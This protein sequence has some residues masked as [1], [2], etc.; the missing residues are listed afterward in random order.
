M[1][2]KKRIENLENLYIEKEI[3]PKLDAELTDWFK[4]NPNYSPC[5][6]PE[7]NSISMPEHL[8]IAFQ[9]RIKGVFIQKKCVP[10]FFNLQKF[11][12]IIYP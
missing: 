5:P 11:W 12:E 1:E 10:N 9:Y 8:S 3:D 2:L 6:Q 4:A 7:S